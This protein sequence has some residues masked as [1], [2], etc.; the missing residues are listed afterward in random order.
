MGAGDL[1]AQTEQVFKN[2][3]RALAAAGARVEDLVKSTVFVVNYK[4]ADR[5]VIAEVRSRFMAARHRRPA[6]WWACRRWW[7]PS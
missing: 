6:R 2:L 4:P 7:C 3:Q 5:E 1:R